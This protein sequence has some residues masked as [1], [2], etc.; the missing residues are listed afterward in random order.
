MPSLQSL[1]NSSLGIGLVLAIGKALP[2]KQGFDLALRVGKWLSK[3]K[4]SPMVRATRANM[5]VVTGQ[6]LSSKE[7]DELV[8]ENLQFT[9]QAQYDF[10]H[11]IDNYPS[12]CERVTLSPKLRGFL[13]TRLG[14]AEGTIMLAPHLS[15]F[16]LGGRAISLNGYDVLALSYPQPQSGYQWQNQLRRD[17]GINI[18]PMSVES[19]RQAKDRLK[20]GG[21]VLTGL[22]RP[23]PETN[24]YPKFF[25]YPAPV[26][27]S[28]VR[29]ALQTCS[30]VF[31]VA[32][33]GTPQTNYRLECSDLIYMTPDDDP[34]KEIEKNAGK[35][36][37]AAEPFIREHPEQWSMTYPVWPFALDEMPK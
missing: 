16:D 24:Y 10:Y 18:V 36:L 21:G 20:K 22:E 26:P 30:A 33:T 23:L 34:V 19:M 31:V 7:L 4:D 35:V 2:P 32:C 25:G 6:K 9:A 3:R 28:Y 12:I 17:A 1:I 14:S 8:L 5:W 27:V 15:N 29:M 11:H 13:D 37:R